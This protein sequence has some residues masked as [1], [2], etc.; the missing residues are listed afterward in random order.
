[1]VTI[2]HYYNQIFQIQIR[3]TKT[4][5]QEIKQKIISLL[6]SIQNIEEFGIKEQEFLQLTKSSPIYTLT[7]LGTYF[8]SNPSILTKPQ[9]IEIIK[10]IKQEKPNLRQIK[11]LLNQQNLKQGLLNEFQSELFKQF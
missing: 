6:I 7:Q 4:P 1:M 11:S 10:E 3:N 2:Q 5:E 9:H 8:Y